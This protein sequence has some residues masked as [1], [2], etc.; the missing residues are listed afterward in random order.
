M[1]PI[2]LPLV[3]IANRNMAYKRSM[4][5]RSIRGLANRSRAYSPLTSDLEL[6]T[7]RSMANRRQRNMAS[8]REYGR[9]GVPLYG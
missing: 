9:R 2:L 6:T 5:N 4:D 8:T 3:S 1:L 7:A